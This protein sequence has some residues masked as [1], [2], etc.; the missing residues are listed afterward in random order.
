MYSSM[1]NRRVDIP[2][3]HAALH[4]SLRSRRADIPVRHTE[5]RGSSL[6]INIPRRREKGVIPT[7]QHP[8]REKGVIPTY[9][10]EKRGSS[11]LINIPV[12][13]TT[14]HPAASAPPLAFS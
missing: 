4:S 2:V 13:P 7:Y 12:I 3:R 1:S 9:Q 10:A 14:N 11:L 5:K 8:G 6:L